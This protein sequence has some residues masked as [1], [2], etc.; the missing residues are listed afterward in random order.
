[1]L[2][3]K[4]EALV[5]SAAA[6]GANI[7][8]LQELFETPYFCQEQKQD[9][10]RLAKVGAA[11]LCWGGRVQAT[12]ELRGST[13]PYAPRLPMRLHQLQQKQQATTVQHGYVLNT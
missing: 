5:R 11:L 13:N 9:Y 4:A 8:L 12:G 3:N 7:I 1:M 6:A 10:Y 2:Q